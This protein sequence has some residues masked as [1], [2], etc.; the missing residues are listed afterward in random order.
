MTAA[1]HAQ[2][3]GLNFEYKGCKSTAAGS[4][5]ASV[6]ELLYP[7]SPWAT[8]YPE[9]FNVTTDAPCAPAYCEV[10]G[11]QYENSSV[12]QFLESTSK[13]SFPSWHVTVAN[14]TEAASGRGA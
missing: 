3:V 5:T 8:D 1:W 12:K 14:N 9:L 6:K 13:S 10:V 2:N 4:M 7:G 11:N